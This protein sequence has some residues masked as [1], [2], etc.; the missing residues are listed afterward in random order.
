M[1]MT[2]IIAVLEYCT[3]VVEYLDTDRYL[4]M[5]ICTYAHVYVDTPQSD[6]PCGEKGQ[7]KQAC[8]MFMFPTGDICNAIKFLT[9]AE[10]RKEK[11]SRRERYLSTCLRLHRSVSGAEQCVVIG[12]GKPI[13]TPR[14]GSERRVNRVNRFSSRPPNVSRYDG[15]KRTF[16]CFLNKNYTFFSSF[17]FH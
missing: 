9:F 8:I 4:G 3:P 14:P 13:V 17:S 11:C 12:R 1:T 2:M 15:D 16:L 6:L 5:H 7:D 10:K